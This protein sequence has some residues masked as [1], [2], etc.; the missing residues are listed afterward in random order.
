MF[1]FKIAQKVSTGYKIIK[2]PDRK[3]L[4]KEFAKIWQD[5]SLPEKQWELTKT[6][7]PMFAKVAPMAAAVKILK[8]ISLKNPR[9]LEI[10][11]STGYYNEVFKKAGI[12]V[13]YEGCDYSETFIAKARTVYPM[14]KFKVCD[15]VKLVYK[16]CEFDI[17]F[18]AGCLLHIISYEK[19]IKEAVR[20]SR[21]YVIFH[22]TPIIHIVDTVFTKKIGYNLS[23]LE[24]VFNE[25]KLIN[26]FYKHGLII[27]AIN[28]H[29]QFAIIGLSE[30]VF[31]KTYICQ[32]LTK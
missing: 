11:C 15:A 17:V 6:Q 13:K 2:N 20:V 8:K 31:M 30:P 14:I 1:R 21:K 10:G 25:E 28:T 24:I 9:L 26:L 27:I 29:G 12:K 23:M 16:D 32:K 4:T 18:S 5:E 3:K 22:R 19:A 7:L